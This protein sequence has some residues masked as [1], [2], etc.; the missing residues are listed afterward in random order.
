MLVLAFLL[1][2]ISIKDYRTH[3]I[4]NSSILLLA[5]LLYFFGTGEVR[6][7]WLFSFVLIS[8]LSVGVLKVGGGDIKLIGVLIAFAQADI[9]LMNYLWGSLSCI[10]ILVL[11]HRVSANKW[12]GNIALAPA[13]CV[14]FLITLL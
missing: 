13:I 6:L 8:V 10:A 1:T 4:A 5:L 7:L 2:Y 12:S 11:L 3:R 9:S 14:P